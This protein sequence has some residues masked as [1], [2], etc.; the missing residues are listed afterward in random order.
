LGDDET[1]QASIYVAKLTLKAISN[2]FQGAHNIKQWLI[3]CAKLIADSNNPV[4]WITPMGL[5]VVQPYRTLSRLDTITTVTQ[6]LRVPPESQ[7]VLN[8][9]IFSSP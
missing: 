9:F 3:Q 1:Y 7:L 4:G 6:I 5:P 2:L 8:L